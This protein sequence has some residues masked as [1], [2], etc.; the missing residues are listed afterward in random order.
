MLSL[1]VS[2]LISLLLVTALT[3]SDIHRGTTIF[4]GI[5]GF[6]ATF[7]LV[8]FLVRKRITKVQKEL[9]VIMLGSLAMA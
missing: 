5:V 6:I 1:L 2:A 7:Y 4:F 3:A 9:E 8:G